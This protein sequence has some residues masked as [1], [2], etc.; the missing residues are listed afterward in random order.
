[1]RGQPPHVCVPHFS[2]VYKCTD[3]INHLRYQK[4]KKKKK[5]EETKKIYY[6]K[7]IAEEKG[8]PPPLFVYRQW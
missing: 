8:T 4:K 5:E 1:M 6:A 7:S 3:T 2:D